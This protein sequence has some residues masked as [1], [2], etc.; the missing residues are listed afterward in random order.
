M[1][2]L[3]VTFSLRVCFFF[4]VSP[5]GEDKCKKIRDKRDTLTIVRCVIQ[6]FI[7]S[8]FN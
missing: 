3:R 5:D 2:W 6:K 8:T 4:L 7:Y 1:I